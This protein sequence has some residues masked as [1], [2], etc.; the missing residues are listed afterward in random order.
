MHAKVLE[1]EGDIEE[2]M[3]SVKGE[4]QGSSVGIKTRAA[5]K[6]WA[7]EFRAK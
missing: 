3:G 1:I 4:F 5:V 7:Y 2:S 6:E